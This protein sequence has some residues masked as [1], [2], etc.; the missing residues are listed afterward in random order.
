MDYITGDDTMRALAAKHGVHEKTLMGH[1]LREGWKADRDKHRGKVEAKT[2]QRIENAQAKEQRSVIERMNELVDDA[3][4]MAKETIATSSGSA[5]D[6][7]SVTS[8]LKDLAELLGYTRVDDE[9]RG[10]SGVIILPPVMEREDYDGS[11]E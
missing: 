4:N 1:R 11:I 2:R 3:I 5:K 10:E 9:T 7:K 8:A 6:L